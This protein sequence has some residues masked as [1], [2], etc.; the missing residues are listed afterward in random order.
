MAVETVCF[1]IGET[2][3]DETRLWNGWAN[4]LGV[5]L[6]VFREIL[7][8]KISEGKSHRE[9]LYHFSPKLD[10]AKAR[11]ERARCGDFDVFDA[12]D[13]YPDAIRC[14]RALR[15]SGFRIGIA[16]NQPLESEAALNKIGFIAD[17][18][19]SSAELGVE[20]PDIAFFKK[21]GALAGAEPF[22]IAYVGD[23][24][25]NDVIPA[26]KAGMV[27]I[28]IE[29]GPWGR[30]HAAMPLITHAGHVIRSLDELPAL[31]NELQGQKS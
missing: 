19:G 26:K 21:L 24:I 30:T 4:Y 16:G 22:E 28:F 1:D 31:L 29:R 6:D 11:A 20:K 15:K 3:V 14:L 9:A 23:R 12:K 17:F 7:V 25:D 2:L 13:F 8:K 5:R 18:V 10:V 27:G